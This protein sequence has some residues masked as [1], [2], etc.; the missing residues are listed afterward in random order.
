[1]V[2]RRLTVALARGGPLAGERPGATA[3]PPTGPVIG[4]RWW[5][6]G[7]LCARGTLRRCSA[8]DFTAAPEEGEMLSDGPTTIFFT[9]SAYNKNTYKLLFDTI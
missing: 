5:R 6:G 9:T 7:G 1:V 2:H 3:A 4:Q 8:E